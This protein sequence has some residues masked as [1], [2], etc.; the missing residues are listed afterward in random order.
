MT[1]SPAIGPVAVAIML[2][3]AM[4]EAVEVCRQGAS[5]LSVQFW[6]EMLGDYAVRKKRLYRLVKK[7]HAM[8]S[9]T[10]KTRLVEIQREKRETGLF[11][12][13]SV[14]RKR[15]ARRQP[16]SAVGLK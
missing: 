15:L 3:A 2:S 5:W 6:V 4:V 14:S 8:P 16:D 13:V 9:E 10:K 1:R 11:I 12:G 7:D